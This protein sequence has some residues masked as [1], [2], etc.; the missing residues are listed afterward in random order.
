MEVTNHLLVKLYHVPQKEIY[1]KHQHWAGT[2]G[3][4]DN[5]SYGRICCCY[6]PTPNDLSL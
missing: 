3:I 1:T 6:K 4:T 2:Y 5:K